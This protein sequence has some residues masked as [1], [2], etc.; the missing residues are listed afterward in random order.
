MQDVAIRPYIK[1]FPYSYSF[2]VY[3]TI[4]LLKYRPKEV[5]KVLLHTRGRQN[6]GVRQIQDLCHKNGI[7]TEFADGLIQKLSASENTYA[8]GVFKKYQAKVDN[9]QNH[10]VLV[11]PEDTGNLGTII[12]SSLGFGVKNIAVIKPGVD[13]F[14]PRTIR[15]SMGAIFQINIEYLDYFEDYKREHKN[16]CYLFMTKAEK[17][18][19][20][21]SFERPF[22]LVFGSESA[23]LSDDYRAKGSTVYIDQS[24][25]IDS[26]NLSTA[27]SIA[28]YCSYTKGTK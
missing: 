28:L 14:D 11:N 26:L 2:G 22:A 13:C 16:K 18:L 3:P 21:V 6:D 1:K 20:G 8:V 9:G 4:E 17:E 7:R 24:K 23:G 15:A 12:R 27:V 25:N 19:S 5:I 10:L